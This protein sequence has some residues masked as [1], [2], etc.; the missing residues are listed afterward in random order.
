MNLLP[1]VSAVN[2]QTS[3]QFA[4]SHSRV[5]TIF[6]TFRTAELNNANNADKDAALNETNGFM[7]PSRVDK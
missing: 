1:A 4:K 5:K 2:S 6:A 3:T 7:W